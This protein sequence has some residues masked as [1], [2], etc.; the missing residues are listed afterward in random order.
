MLA[1]RSRDDTT[2]P[3]PTRNRPP[4]TL[5]RDSRRGRVR[6]R[7]AVD[8]VA[9]PRHSRI[10]RQMRPGG[11]IIH[12][13]PAAFLQRLKDMTHA[14]GGRVAQ[15]ADDIH[16]H[17]DIGSHVNRPRRDI[18]DPALGAGKVPPHGVQQARRA[19]NSD[20]SMRHRQRPAELDGLQRTKRDEGQATKQLVGIP[21]EIPNELPD[22]GRVPGGVVQD[23]RHQSRDA[24]GTNDHECQF[25]R[26]RRVEQR[27]ELREDVMMAIVPGRRTKIV[28]Q[29][30]IVSILNPGAATGSYGVSRS[31][32]VLLLILLASLSSI[33]TFT[34]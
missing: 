3:A 22:A 32:V 19:I 4:A 24:A 23:G 14:V 2:T 18:D 28:K 5:G 34:M 26:A 31:F 11:A 12:D 17:N 8:L 10:T 6:R 21:G 15:S 9:D 27:I 25:A 33:S 20:N 30:R 1:V 16:R 29:Q 7:D 13:D